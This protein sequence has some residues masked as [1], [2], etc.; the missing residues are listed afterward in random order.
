[1][2]PARQSDREKI[3]K[4]CWHFSS[5]NSLCGQGLFHGGVACVAM[6]MKAIPWLA[7]VAIGVTG[8]SA[9]IIAVFLEGWSADP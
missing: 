1:V 7:A 8:F 9:S 3:G 6:N 2:L 4:K 5:G